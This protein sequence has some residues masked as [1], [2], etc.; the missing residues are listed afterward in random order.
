MILNSTN[1]KLKNNWFKSN[2]PKSINSYIVDTNDTG[3]SCGVTEITNLNT[4][5]EH[6]RNKVK[7]QFQ[8]E[9]LKILLDQ[10]KK[11]TGGEDYETGRVTKQAFLIMSTTVTPR[12][13]ERTKLLDSVC[14]SRTR[15]RK[16]PNSGNKIKIWTY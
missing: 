1:S 3:I 7:P 6:I 16:N 12:D 8:K 2:R 4:T 15:I 10:V 5:I 13:I 9:A 14:S 11:D